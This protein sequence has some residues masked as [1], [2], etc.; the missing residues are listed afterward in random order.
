M[1]RRTYESIGNPL[2]GRRSIVISTSLGK[3]DGAEVVRSL[4]EAINLLHDSPDPAFIIGGA[5]LYA[6]ALP[7]VQVMHLTEIEEVVEG[8]AF[9]P[10]FDQSEW[11]LISEQPHERDDRH[12]FAFLFRTY[13]RRYA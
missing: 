2:P 8:D 1:G 12:G 11:K 13:A 10:P 4:D 3:I 9:F 6:A 5:V 7:H